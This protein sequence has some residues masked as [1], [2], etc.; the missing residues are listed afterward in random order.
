MPGDA[1]PWRRRRAR[2]PRRARVPVTVPRLAG[3]PACPRSGRSSAPA[4][5][6]PG[7]RSRPTSPC[8]ASANTF[9]SVSQSSLPCWVHAAW[10]IAL[11]M[12]RN[13]GSS[14]ARRSP[15]VMYARAR[16]EA[17]RLA[18]RGDER[19]P[20]R[21]QRLPPDLAVGVRPRGRSGSC[22]S[23]RSGS[24]PAS[25]AGDARAARRVVRRLHRAVHALGA[26]RARVVSDA[27]DVATRRR[28]RRPARRCPARGRLRLGQV[29][30]RVEVAGA[31]GDRA[32]LRADQRAEALRVGDEPLAEP[33]GVLVVDHRR[34]LRAVVAR[35]AARSPKRYICIR[36]GCRPAA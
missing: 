1:R 14:G 15:P 28:A 22:R 19:G 24:R 20:E 23:R 6:R 13:V 34:V 31:L 3:S 2:R 26:D 9:Q 7:P 11:R 10:T 27:A 4:T 8:R 36:P 12:S 25:A 29:V 30:H 16:L 5:C 35:R 33:V 17:V 32:R 21:P 18:V